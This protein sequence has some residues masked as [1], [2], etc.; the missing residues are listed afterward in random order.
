VRTFPTKVLGGRATFLVLSPR[1]FPK[2]QA[3]IAPQAVAPGERATL[4]LQVADAGGLHAVRIRAKAPTAQ[5]AEWLHQVVIAGKEPKEVAL[6]VA[7]N[8]P[9]G[10]WTVE[11]IDLFTEEPVAVTLTVKAP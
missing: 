7:F 1:P 8:D 6:P 11:V 2:V 4:R 9:P 5:P 10:P 3:A